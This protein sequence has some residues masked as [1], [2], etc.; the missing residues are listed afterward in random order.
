MRIFNPGISLYPTN[1]THKSHKN[2]S[3]KS[4]KNFSHKSHK[5]YPCKS[6]KSYPCKSHKSF[7]CKSN[8]VPLQISNS[9][10]QIPL[11]NS[12]NSPHKFHISPPRQEIS[13][14]PDNSPEIRKVEAK[15][16]IGYNETRNSARGVKGMK[17]ESKTIASSGTKQLPAD[18]PKRKKDS[19]EGRRMFLMVLP[20]LILSFLFCY[21]PLHG[22]IYA[23][24]DYRAPLKLSQCEFV[25]LK[26]FKLLVSSEAQLRQ[27]GQVMKNTFAMSFLG[28][29]TSF[30]PVLFAVFL[31]EMRSRKC[32]NLVQTLTTLPNF[33]SWTLIY[34]VAFSLLSNSGMVNT[35]LQQ[36]GIIREPLRILDSGE[37]VWLFMI[38]LSTWKGLGWGAIMYIAA[39][40]GIDQEM[41]EAARV[42]GAGRWQMIRSITIPSLMPTYFVLLILSV[43]NFLS[44]G[45]EQYFVFQNAFN[46]EHIQVLDLYVY[47]I[48]LG[49]K[50][51]SLATAVGMLKTTVSITLLIIVNHV[52]KRVRGESII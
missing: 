24:Y 32:K 15:C 44:N 29:A 2:F 16:K 21:F 10:A 34:S 26:W 18:I 6:H 38:L 4:H 27:L 39:L 49:G 50:S 22:W 23:L 35:V 11:T 47:N 17:Q 48:G 30:L 3:H 5:S 37:H 28:I 9:P 36:L 8:K 46:K 40:S 1:I 52:S 25:G 20:F 7:S 33:I 12:T 19:R 14:N 45:M 42:D 13:K 43:A 51:F 31:N 41:Y